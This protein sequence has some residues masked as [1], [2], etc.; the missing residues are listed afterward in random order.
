MTEQQGELLDQIEF[1]VK[2]AS[3]F[4]DD[5]NKEMVQAIDYQIS[6]RKKQLCVF[7]IVI[8]VLGVIALIIAFAT[9]SLEK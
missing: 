3:D 4:V 2:S 6:I 7:M 8:V 5:G 9:G 1:Q